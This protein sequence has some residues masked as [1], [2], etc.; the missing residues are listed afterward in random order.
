MK[1][2]M[3]N[4]TMLSI[5]ITLFLCS[6]VHA[7]APAVTGLA[8]VSLIDDEDTDL[9]SQEPPTLV[10]TETGQLSR[11]FGAHSQSIAE[12]N[13]RRLRHIGVCLY[14]TV[15]AV[16]GL[17]LYLFRPW[18]DDETNTALLET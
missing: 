5:A 13:G 14:C 7:L 9:E 8:K 10:T 4:V 3:S 15:V 6:N 1:Q 2:R 18:E 12:T 11:S 17:G 16:T